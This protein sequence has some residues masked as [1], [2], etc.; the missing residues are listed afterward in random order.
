MRRFYQTRGRWA[1]AGKCIWITGLPGSGKSTL[2]RL[3]GQELERR[4][5]LVS[6]LDGDAVRASMSADLGFGRRDRD[7]NV[8][9]VAEE[10]AALVAKGQVVIVSLVSPYRRARRRARQVV[11]EVGEFIEVYADCPIGTCVERDPKGLYARALAGSITGVTGID[12][13]YEPPLS[14]E[15]VVCTDGPSERESA[16]A[17]LTCLD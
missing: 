12:D 13:P 7:E 15:V 5:Q 3:V 11:S 6:Y 8:A 16:A 4:G 17:V 10:A 14:C 9:R 2:A 1:V